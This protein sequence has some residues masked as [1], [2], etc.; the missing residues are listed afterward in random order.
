VGPYYELFRFCP[1]CGTRYGPSSLDERDV[2]YRC[3]ACGFDFFQNSLPAATVVIPRKGVPEEVVL[4]VRDNE[5]GRGLLALPG[6]FLR[7]GESPA[8]GARREA[9]E[10]ASLDPVIEQLLVSTLVDYEYL[11]T[12]L[13]TLELAFLAAPVE[14]DLGR[15]RTSEARG[16]AFHD[17]RE[18]A[19]DRG[20][21]AFPEQADVLAEYLVRVAESTGR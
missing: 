1:R 10:E 14:V 6:G 4:L 9:R 13:W 16:V 11:G 21:L 19:R 15:I 17:A 7:Y 3:Q 5:P 12:R 2:V 8:S 20:R 18:L